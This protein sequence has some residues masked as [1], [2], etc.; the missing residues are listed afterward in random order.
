M[1]R[2]FWRNRSPPMSSTRKIEEEAADQTAGEDGKVYVAVSD[3]F[4][5][6][7][8]TLVWAIQN[9]H[10]D[11]KIVLAHVHVPAQMIPFT[12]AKFH[13]TKM[14]EQEVRAYRH[15]EREKMEANL[16][17]YIKACSKL[18]VTAEKIVIEMDDVAQG[19]LELISLHG[20][21]RLIMGAASDKHYS[22]KMKTPKSMKAITVLEKAVSVCKIWFVCKGA[23][24]CTR[25]ATGTI[26]AIPSSPAPS[27][28][29][30]SI[31][32]ISDGIGAFSLH[33]GTH[34]VTVNSPP[35]T[36]WSTQESPHSNQLGGPALVRNQFG[37]LFS[38]IK[39]EHVS[40]LDPWEG[41]PRHKPLSSEH[42]RWNEHD[43]LMSMTASRAGDDVSFTGTMTHPSE[44]H[45]SDD[46]TQFLSPRT[47]YH[48]AE[49][50]Y[51]GMYEKYK[52]AL[53]EAEAA[54]KE[55]YEES[56]KRRRAERDLLSALQKA[57]ET[58]TLYQNEIKKRQ[59]VEEA[60]IQE[61]QENER[62]RSQTD[63]IFTKLR[64]AEERKLIN[65]QR[66]TELERATKDLE[67][68]LAAT[69][70]LMQSVKSKH[71]Q[72]QQE[73][74]SAL[75]E[76]EELKK[77]ALQGT[78]SIAC[79]ELGMEFSYAELEAATREFS[80]Q[81]KIGE[82][83]FGSV[84]KG[85]LRNTPVAV[86]L[87]HQ[88]GMQGI[89]EFHQEI[90]VL[91]KVRHPNLVTLIGSCSEACALVYEYLPNG[92]LEDRLACTDNSPPL[93]WQ[94][95]TRIMGEICAA[96]I[97][98]HSSR[99][100]PVVHGDLKPDNILLD[101]NLISKLSDFGICRMLIQT[102]AAKSSIYRTANPKSTLAYMDPELVS[103]GEVTPKSDVYSFGIII[104]RLLT[105]WQP[106]NISNKVEEA[107]EN[108]NLHSV[109]DPSAGEWPF[110]QASQLAHLG[111]RCTELSRRKR[112]DLMR[113]VWQVIKPMMKVAALS[114]RPLSFISASDDRR[115]PS[116]F[117]CPIFQEVMKDPHIA[118]DGFTYEAEAIKGW[119]D[120]GHD[121]S[122][123][124]NLKLIHHELIPNRA[125]RSA[126]LEWVPQLSQ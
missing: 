41:I 11:S 46:D 113:D 74:D 37:N 120:S 59:G 102:N 80:D 69:R 20:V 98:L 36:N 9:L 112:A 65:E 81:M 92:S 4:K 52:E 68:K 60:L 115:I 16:N 48:E 85:L 101:A 15:I 47:R 107:I 104:L 13:Y 21:T 105:G 10:R 96:L 114:A 73:R 57:R 55:A 72:A 93:T 95:R 40:P 122:P 34:E 25:D 31:S 24:I 77:N 22:K 33:N 91:T 23:L 108:G 87:L 6:G 118:A 54:K 7:R 88:D 58:D 84:Y 94:A 100:H 78:T 124:T 32:S 50:M 83:G 121:T 119:L 44:H 62:T 106:L 27:S 35:P 103:T 3:D 67:D 63:S 12:G 123:M 14:K 5:A 53:N 75:N 28:G 45:D 109:I 90:K 2:S 19:I 89:S 97:F 76:V 30:G 111:L 43:D 17:Q 99:P 49:W 64:E 66:I 8:S 117:I 29:T 110:V 126:I 70:Y 39:P 82:G 56:N 26:P 86:K 61:R 51:S 42:F 125:L 18:K 79:K 71:E 1:E 38:N 116:Y